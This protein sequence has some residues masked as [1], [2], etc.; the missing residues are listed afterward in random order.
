M[1]MPMNPIA[2]SV[3]Q[4]TVVQRQQA[5]QRDRELGRAAAATRVITAESDRLELEVEN[6]ERVTPA[7]DEDDHDQRGRRQR[8]LAQA[9][10]AADE[11]DDRPS[12][13]LTA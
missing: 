5:E 12:L 9:R 6:A 8:R 2:G 11:Q 3:L 7:R 4:S 10:S 13:D 1:M